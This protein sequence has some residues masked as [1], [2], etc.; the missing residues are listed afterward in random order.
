MLREK[1][2]RHMIAVTC[3]AI[4]FG[5]PAQAQDLNGY[6]MFFQ[7]Q[8][9]GQYG[10]NWYLLHVS[11]EGAYHHFSVIAD[12]KFPYEGTFITACRTDMQ[13]SFVPNQNY[14]YTEVSGEVVN[15]FYYW[16]CTS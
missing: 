14:E 16:V 13:D 2:M 3:L 4:M 9:E 1:I 8:F 6:D 5:L 7:E 10:N 12:G 11:E 15:A